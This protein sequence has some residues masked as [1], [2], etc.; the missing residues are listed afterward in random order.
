MVIYKWTNIVE[1]D[2]MWK[3]KMESWFRSQA[4]KLRNADMPD[5]IRPKEKVKRKPLK[6]VARQLYLDGK[7]KLSKAESVASR[8]L[9][10][11][12]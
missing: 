1:V 4:D 3:Q 11:S 5:Q 9:G 10:K 12:K 2:I 7:S 8:G 6:G